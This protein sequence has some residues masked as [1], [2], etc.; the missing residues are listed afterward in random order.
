MTRP[1]AVQ[2]LLRHS[3]QPYLCCG[4]QD[5]LPTPFGLVRSGVAPDHQDTKVPTGCLAATARASHLPAQRHKGLGAAR[6]PARPAH[7]QPCSQR[8]RG[9]ATI[10]LGLVVHPR[11][12]LLLLLLSAQN[13]TNQFTRVC[14][15]P[16]LA[17]FGNVTLGRDVSLRELRQRFHAV[18]RPP[19]LRCPA[20]PRCCARLKLDEGGYTRDGSQSRQSAAGRLPLW[21]P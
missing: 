1:P 13:V 21:V 11:L 10:F 6:L 18:R 19:C 4:P 7:V 9:S 8:A 15:D 3:L 20:A 2:A 16:R 17:Y 12:L 14:H 5:R